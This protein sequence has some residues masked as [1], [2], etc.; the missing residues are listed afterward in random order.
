MTNAQI[1]FSNQIALMEAGKIG[2]TGRQLKASWVDKE[3]NEKTEIINEPEPIHTFAEWKSRGYFVNKGEKA[4]ARFTIWMFT[5]RPNKAAQQEAEKE[6][7]EAAADPHY[8]MKEAC[9]FTMSQTTAAQ[10]ML[11]AVI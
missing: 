5:D 2:T 6:G 11:P 4:V 3:G 9:F 8:Y 10:K 7:K 1:I